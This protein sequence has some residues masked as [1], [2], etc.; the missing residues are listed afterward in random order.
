VSIVIWLSAGWFRRG[1][2]Q[3]GGGRRGWKALF[4]RA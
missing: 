1:V 2:L 3:S 4:Q